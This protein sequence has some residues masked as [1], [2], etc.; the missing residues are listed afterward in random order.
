[1]FL[2]TPTG[3]LTTL[4]SFCSQPYCVDGEY[5]SALFQGSDGIFYGTTAH[6]GAN[7]Y[8]TVFRITPSGNFAV[9]YSFCA[10]ANCVDGSI[11]YSGVVQAA[12]GNF[13]GT[14]VSGGAAGLGTVFR[15]TP[16]GR[17]TVLYSFCSEKYCV[18][19]EVPVTLV[20]D[21][22]GAFYGTTAWG[23]ANVYGTVFRI[24]ARG[25]LT[26]LHS[27]DSTDGENPYGPLIQ[28][29]NGDFYGTTVQG[30]SGIQG[31]VYRF[32]RGTD[33]SHR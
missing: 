28:T 29:T 8:G 3:D 5:P 30:G 4:Y 32:S 7:G 11:P 9:I 24:T 25:K 33:P 6:G 18:D 15:L 13:F 27:F 23:G 2:I 26:R 21:K 12:D 31:T 20:Q 10:Q 17:L 14:T 1:V 22:D 16:H 19:G